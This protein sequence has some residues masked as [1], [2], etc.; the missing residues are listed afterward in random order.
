MEGGMTARETIPGGSERVGSTVTADGVNF[1]VY[2]KHATAVELLLFDGPDAPQPAQTF[3]LSPERNRTYHYWHV[4]VR[5][6]SAGQVYGYRAYGPHRPEAGLRFDPTKL[7]L[8][9]YAKAVVNTENYRRSR[10]MAPGD[11]TPGAMRAGGVNPRDYA[12]EGD[13]PLRR[14][15]ADPVIYE[16]HVAGFTRHP[17]SGLAPE[18]RGT[19]TGLVEKIPYLRDLGIQAVELMPV[20]Q[21]DAQAAPL[22]TNYWGY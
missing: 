1:C 2:S 14:P 3:R 13:K 21:F 22:N 4:E 6:A 20:Q 16:M 15:S 10:A 7:L 12:W 9:P 19:Y 17:S 5:G 18:R 8:D 11:N